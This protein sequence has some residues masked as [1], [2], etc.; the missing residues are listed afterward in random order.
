VGAGF[1]FRRPLDGNSHKP[2]GTRAVQDIYST[3]TAQVI[4]AIE[5]DG[6]APWS[7]PWVGCGKGA[8]MPLNAKSEKAY[9]G[10]NVIALLCSAW[11]QDF[12]SG[13]WMTYKQAKELGGK[14]LKGQKGTKIVFWKLLEDKDPK[15][16]IPMARGYTVFNA[17]Q[18]EGLPKEFYVEVEEA[19]PQAKED[20]PNGAA[21]AILEASACPITHTGVQAFYQ[22]STDSITLPPRETFTSWAGY[23]TTAFHE[24]GHSTGHKS[25]LDRFKGEDMSFGGHS[26]SFEE[27][28]A[29]FSAC[30][31]A[32]ECGFARETLGNAIS[33][34]KIWVS[35]LKEN[36]RALAQAAQRAQ[37]AVDL[38]LGTVAKGSEEA[39]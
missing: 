7:R 3:I 38:I 35:K 33:Y 12:N 2:Q 27:L 32:A 1:F 22:P 34:L 14:V 15:K 29:E 39:A 20:A 18:C 9:R 5:R 6:V 11:A 16:T 23:Y 17:E 31:L 30:F 13:Y 21:E 25:R 37:K 10:V 36:P 24:M 8:R 19:S 26:Y 4:E 28:V